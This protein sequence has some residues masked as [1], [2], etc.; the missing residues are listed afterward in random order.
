MR[1]HLNKVSQLQSQ[2]EKIIQDLEDGKINKAEAADKITAIREKM[3]ETIKNIRL[4][5]EQQ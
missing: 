4:G 3:D 5:T 2:L 1:T